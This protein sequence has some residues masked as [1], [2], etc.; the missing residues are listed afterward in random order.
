MPTATETA[1]QNARTVAEQ[2]KALA[3][4]TV[5]TAQQVFQASQ[6]A[7]LTMLEGV[8]QTSNRLFEVSRLMLDQ[9]ELASRE[10]KETLNR[11][12]SQTRDGQGSV[13]TL[14]RDSARIVENTWLGVYRNGRNN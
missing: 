1:A 5:S 6:Q 11:L 3:D 7:Y 2:S 9:A 4:Q 12:A 10:S 8:F 13:M 14:A